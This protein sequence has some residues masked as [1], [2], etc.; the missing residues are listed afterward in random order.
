MK[1][2]KKCLALFPLIALRLTGCDLNRRDT[3]VV[4]AIK[5]DK[6]DPGVE[7][8]DGESLLT[9]KGAPSYLLGKEGDS[10]VD[11]LTWDYYTKAD[12]K[13]IKAGNIKGE[14]GNKGDVGAKG[15][16][17][18]PGKDGESLLNG[19]GVPSS[20]L[21]KDGDSYVDTLTWD[22]YTKSNGKWTKTGNFKGGNGDNGSQGSRGDD[23]IS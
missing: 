22:Y 15:D 11:T 8:K 12:G 23:A 4:S 2:K 20:F 17:G 9:G 7:G 16:P 6:G 21:G 3:S 10:Y 1:I 18:L 13:W 19:K 5:G 14:K